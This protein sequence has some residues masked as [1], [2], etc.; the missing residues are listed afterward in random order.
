MVSSVGVNDSK[1]ILFPHNLSPSVHPTVLP[2]FL[3]KTAQ[4]CSLRVIRTHNS[5][6]LTRNPSR[7]TVSCFG[8]INSK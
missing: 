6:G 5:V 7:K 8:S 1:D 2:V 4:C 3:C